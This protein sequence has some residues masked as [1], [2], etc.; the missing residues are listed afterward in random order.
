[1]EELISELHA[2]VFG[3]T[4]EAEAVLVKHASEALLVDA[5]WTLGVEA[6]CA[7]D[8]DPDAWERMVT[9]VKVCEEK[10][11][12]SRKTLVERLE[13]ALLESA[14][15]H[16]LKPGVLKKR[17]VR[18]NTMQMYVQLKFNL[19]HESHEGYSKLAVFLASLE[20]GDVDGDVAVATVEALIGRFRLD[21]NRVL[22]CVLDAYE[23]RCLRG[24]VRSADATFAR[25]LAL[26]RGS[27]LA[28]ILGFKLQQMHRRG[29]R[30][31]SSLLRLISCLIGFHD[32]ALDA[33]WPHLA[34][35]DESIATQQRECEEH[36]VKRA[37]RL[38]K[39]SL[40]SSSDAGS[41][42][43]GDAKTPPHPSAAALQAVADAA[44]ANELNQ[45]FG[46]L[47]A[48]LDMDVWSSAEAVL[49]RLA[50]LRISASDDRAVA[51]ALVNM[52]ERR[53]A[54]LYRPIMT[55]LPS[56]MISSDHLAVATMDENEN[57]DENE[58]ENEE[59]PLTCRAKATLCGEM[60]K[61]LKW[62][63]HRL[64]LFP[65]AIARVTRLLVC[66]YKDQ[67]RLIH[68]VIVL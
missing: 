2:F 42:S 64:G 39:V 35:S 16:F 30:T 41:N 7:A 46:L 27:N 59:S 32:L 56:M 34:P 12:V 29:E 21:P 36:V 53:T 28:H 55:L 62:I 54:V 38:G 4:G 68:S 52:L 63:R 51:R 40:S 22:D 33:I 45:K 11:I 24:P 49:V 48:L 67:V 43:G 6:E 13:P 15:S 65:G 23:Q 25:L 57:G 60:W 1:M 61:Q 44:A 8:E 31:S 37:K 9:L 19:M 66:I 17:M 3:G 10:Q 26:F 47:V 18:V 5:L 58:N 50:G 14:A 20:S